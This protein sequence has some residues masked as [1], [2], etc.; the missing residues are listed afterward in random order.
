MIFYIP[1]QTQIIKFYGEQNQS[2]VGMEE[3]AELI[4]A[5]SKV[6][7][8]STCAAMDKARLNLIEEVADVLICIQQLM[9]MYKIEEAEI[10][11]IIDKKC[12]RQEERVNA[13]IKRQGYYR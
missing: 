8:A 10:Q 1:D 5:I 4:Q 13:E 2:V 6:Y 3:C 12:K 7:R 9:E 11:E